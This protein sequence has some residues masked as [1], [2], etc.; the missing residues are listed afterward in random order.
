MALCARQAFCRSGIEWS[1]WSRSP[2]VPLAPKTGAT[3]QHRK[4]R[5]YRGWWIS[6]IHNDF[7]DVARLPSDDRENPRPPRLRTSF[8][9]AED[10]PAPLRSVTGNCAPSRSAK[11]E[12]TGVNVS[13]IGSAPRAREKEPVPLR[14]TGPCRKMKTAPPPPR[15]SPFRRNGEVA[16]AAGRLTE[17]KRA[18]SR[19]C[20]A[21]AVLPRLSGNAWCSAAR[22]RRGATRGGR[23]CIRWSRPRASPCAH[24]RH[25]RWRCG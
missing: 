12:R 5:P 15:S 17:G 21:A 10:G 6:R 24:R 3:R 18:R 13:A 1:Q 25:C 20:A 19:P 11:T 22:A 8:R 9:P 16:A 4:N 14:A 2:W 7:D 23:P